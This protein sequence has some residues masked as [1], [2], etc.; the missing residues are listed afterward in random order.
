VDDEAAGAGR[1][2]A[3]GWT[4]GEARL[5]AT[6][7]LRYLEAGTGP[8][9][10]LLHGFP[11][12]SYGWRNQIAAVAAAGY[13]V[14]APDLRGYNRSSKP[15]RVAAYDLPVLAGDVVALVRALGETSV[16][17]LVGHDWGGV[18]AWHVAERHPALVERLVILNAPHPAVFARELRTP[19]QATRS[20]YVAFF[21][22]P[23]VPE[24]LLRGDG[25]FGPLLA[26][27]ERMVLRPGALTA[28]DVERHRE[29]IAQPGALTAALNYYRALGRRVARRGLRAGLVEREGAPRT[30]AAPTLV[31][32]GNRDPALGERLTEG[33]QAWAP[34][35]RVRHFPEAGHWVQLDSP[36]AVNA[37][38]LGWLAAP[39]AAPG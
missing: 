3:P 10:L 33:L 34:R 36:D 12:F 26:A 17:A 16:A 19:G 15:R 23:G 9:V 32:W 2:A 18:I 7:T 1:R 35:L 8:L 37:E 11:D 38:I 5:G 22:L 4:E 39:G 20:L 6:I 30:V 21:Q 25:R 31:L 29:A 14:V 24:L 13:R 27:F 28:A